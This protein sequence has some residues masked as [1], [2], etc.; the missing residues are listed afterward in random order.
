MEFTS[1]QAKNETGLIDPVSRTSAVMRFHRSR[2]GWSEIAA[3]AVGV[4]LCISRQQN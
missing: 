2:R 3:V 4:R 1:Q